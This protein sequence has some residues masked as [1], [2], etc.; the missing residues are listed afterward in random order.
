MAIPRLE[1]GELRLKLYANELYIDHFDGEEKDEEDL[2][3]R[4]VNWTNAR[5]QGLAYR[6]RIVDHE[7]SVRYDSRQTQLQGR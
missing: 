5:P 1:P 4:A 2:R 6:A 3:R 7:G